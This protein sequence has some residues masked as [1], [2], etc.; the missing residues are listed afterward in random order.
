MYSTAPGEVSYEDDD[1]QHGVF[2]YFIRDGLSGKAASKADGMITFDDLLNYVSGQ[3]RTYGISER[4]VQKPYQ[5]G[6]STG[7]FL[8]AKLD[9]GAS[10]SGPVPT[11]EK[12]AT[13]LTEPPLTTP[14]PMA[15]SAAGDSSIRGIA[16][17][18]GE[19]GGLEAL[20]QVWRNVATNDLYRFRFDSEHLV[21]YQLRTNQ[22]VADLT[23]KPD[24]KD[25]KNFGA[26][27]K[28]PSS[29]WPK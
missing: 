12:P 6:D 17:I 29:A 24:K 2:S 1:L 3:M 10:A 26:R 13:A 27:Q 21:I 15:P 28:W 14:P 7:D 9:P 20:P 19:T 25:H 22:V 8:L 11:R 5:L 16:T 4:R 23:L 18:K